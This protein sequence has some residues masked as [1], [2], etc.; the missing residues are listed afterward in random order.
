M[1]SNIKTDFKTPQR[2]L[3]TNNSNLSTP[4]LVPPSPMLQQMGYGTGKY[5]K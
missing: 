2:A 4:I 1:S 3:R 5:L